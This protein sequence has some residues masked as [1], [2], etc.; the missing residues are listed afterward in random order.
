MGIC[1]SDN[2]DK[3][4][5][6]FSNIKITDVDDVIELVYRLGQNEI[7][8]PSEFI[9]DDTIKKIF[10]ERAWWNCKEI[11]EAGLGME[12]LMKS[13]QGRYFF[14]RKIFFI[15]MMCYGEWIDAPSVNPYLSSSFCGASD[16][17]KKDAYKLFM[18]PKLRDIYNRTI[19]IDYIFRGHII[20]DTVDELEILGKKDKRDTLVEFYFEIL[21]V[22]PG[23]VTGGSDGFTAA[24]T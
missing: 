6:K 16:Q 10:K 11:Y 20:S 8:F 1:W 19:I 18:I 21:R 24:C 3:Q 12:Y 4:I 17:E 23:Y 15:N 5:W 9:C 13:S 22:I 7:R 14:N 2:F